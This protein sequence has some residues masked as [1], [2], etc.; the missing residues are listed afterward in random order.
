[1]RLIV[2]FFLFLAHL[3]GDS[4]RVGIDFDDKRTYYPCF[5]YV[6]YEIEKNSEILGRVFVEDFYEKGAL[7]LIEAFF[8]INS[9]YKSTCSKYPIAAFKNKDAAIE[10]TKRYGGS[11]RNFDFALFV[12]KKDVSEDMPIIEKSESEA[13]KKGRVLFE[14]FCLNKIEN[15]KNLNSENL[16]FLEAYSKNT[17]KI[18]EKPQEAIAVQKEAKCPVCGMFVSK[19]PKW[20]AQ[21]I[22]EDGH[23]HYFDGVKDMMKFYFDPQKFTSDNHRMGDIKHLFVSDYYNL[24]KMEANK[25]FF[26]LGSNIYGPM[27]RELIPFKSYEDADSFKKSHSGKTILRFDE[28][29]PK[30]VLGLDK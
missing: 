2:S 3:Y 12:A 14:K 29:T 7:P 21:I 28:I 22:F 5:A 24:Q 27:G 13:I 20:A 10:F 23:S 26:V 30:A 16:S 4:L 17:Q 1:M 15:C 6:A 11:I 18:D 9:K 19:Y 8:V 25:A